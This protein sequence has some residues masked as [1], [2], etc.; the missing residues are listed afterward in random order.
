[1]APKIL[2]AEAEEGEGF[3]VTVIPPQP[4]GH[5]QC[6]DDYLRARA[7][8]RVLRLGNGWELFDRVD[9]KTRRSAEKAD[10]ERRERG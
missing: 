2:L 8:A 7:Y 9:D 3:C 4:I 5:D 6:F 1:M 10:Q